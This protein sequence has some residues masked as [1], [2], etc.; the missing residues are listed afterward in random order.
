MQLK[1]K[2]Y[3]TCPCQRTY[4]RSRKGDRTLAFFLRSLSW[5]SHFMS[6]HVAVTPN[7]GVTKGINDGKENSYVGSN[8]PIAKANKVAFV[9]YIVCISSRGNISTRAYSGIAYMW[10]TSK[11]EEEERIISKLSLLYVIRYR[12]IDNWIFYVSLTN[13]CDESIIAEAQRLLR[14]EICLIIKYVWL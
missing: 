1:V 8:L 9:R 12:V 11:G 10:V 6:R 14:G 5:T 4:Q 7:N 13:N 3:S 2:V